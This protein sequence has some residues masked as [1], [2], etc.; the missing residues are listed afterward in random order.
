MVSDAHSHTQTIYATQPSYDSSVGDAVP[1]VEYVGS[2][3]TGTATALDALTCNFTAFPWMGDSGAETTS[4]GGTQPTPL[5]APLTFVCDTSKTYG[6]TVARVATTGN[7]STGTAV[8]I[9]SYVPSTT[10]AFLTIGK[11]AAAI[12]V[13]NNSNHSR[14]DVGG[15][16]IYLDN[17]TY[18]FTGSSNTYGGGNPATVVH[19]ANYVWFDNC[20]INTSHTDLLDTNG[21]NIFTRCTITQLGQGLR[22]FSTQNRPF[23]LIRG[24][25]FN[26]FAKAISVRGRF[27]AMPAPPLTLPME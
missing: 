12:G 3:P 27:W 25:T 8:D 18:V 21:S 1:V 19:G 26:G 5:P 4:T 16:I 22:P 24:N 17:G 6:Q 2:I 7:D 23:T 15:G 13:Y 11:A 9:G 10:P 20:V 14:N